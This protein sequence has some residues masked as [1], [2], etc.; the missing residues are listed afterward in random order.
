MDLAFDQLVEISMPAIVGLI[1]FAF[2]VA[3]A[4]LF[5]S[6]VQHRKHAPL[7]LWSL[8]FGLGAA[9]T[10]LVAMRGQIAD[11]WTIVVANALIAAAY[12]A[13]WSGS[14]SFDGRPVR[15]LLSVA[16]LALWALVML[17]PDARHDLIVRT[18]LMTVIGVVYTLATVVELW[19]SRS[20][21]LPSLWPAIVLLLLHALSL[22]VRIPIVAA[23]AGLTPL[24]LD[25]FAFVVFE[26]VL[27][28]MAGAYLF[29]SLVREKVSATYR[30]AASVDALTGVANRRTFML[31]GARMLERTA[32][33][34]LPSSLLLFDIDYFKQI[35]DAYGHSV[36]D[37]V[38]TTFCDVAQRQ[39][40]PVDLFGRIGGEEFA[41]LLCGANAAEAL[42][43]AERVRFAFEG[44]EQSGGGQS[45]GST[46]SVGIT[47][48]SAPDENLQ[49]RLDDAD[50][51]LYRAKNRGRNQVAESFPEEFVRV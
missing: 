51:A 40:R 50:R 2:L 24:Q 16:G 17:V 47:T 9:G 14:R 26:S 5:L 34:G 7:G 46:V 35:N 42:V 11:F 8:A 21:A 43:I 30:W 23:W 49:K 18:N 44:A 31:R 15:P 4:L 13:M 3:S 32:A 48:S 25:M 19:R 10:A 41:C 27:L 38:L 36:G 28:A 6:Y 29:G 37:R 45:F 12:G 20:N 33:Q 39:L 22:P 1:G